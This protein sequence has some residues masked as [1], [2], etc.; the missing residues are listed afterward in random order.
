[1]AKLIP[2]T[3]CLAVITIH[4]WMDPAL[5]GD[6]VVQASRTAVQ[7]DLLNLAARAQQYYWCPSSKGGGGR[8]FVG[9]DASPTGLTKLTMTPAT[10]N[11]VFSIQTAGDRTSVGLQG[12]GVERGTDGNL[13]KVQ[14]IVFPDSIAVTFTN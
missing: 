13:I 1:M 5:A 12:L 8:T 3:I 9:L 14:M 11:G 10:S 2:L 4:I 7:A 6:N